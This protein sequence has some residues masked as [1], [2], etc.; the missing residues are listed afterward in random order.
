MVD[1]VVQIPQGSGGQS[2]GAHRWTRLTASKSPYVAGLRC[3]S[4]TVIVEMLPKL[5][6][7][8]FKTY[9]VGE[10]GELVIH[11]RANDY[12]SGRKT[13]GGVCMLRAPHPASNP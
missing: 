7:F 4:I 12:S 1:Y 2:D 11:R 9:R 13:A 10:I 6:H 5:A 3:G 8:C